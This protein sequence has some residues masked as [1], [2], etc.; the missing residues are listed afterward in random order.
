MDHEEAVDVDVEEERRKHDARVV[1]A[2]QAYLRGYAPATVAAAGTLAP[3]T[4]HAKCTRWG[5]RSNLN[6]VRS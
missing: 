4:H 3:R 6:Y 5:E 1:V 2:E